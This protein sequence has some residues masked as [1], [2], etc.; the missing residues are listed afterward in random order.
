MYQQQATPRE[1]RSRIQDKTLK[2]LSVLLRSTRTSSSSG[3]PV[4]EQI[5]FV[6]STVAQALVL[7]D[8]DKWLSAISLEN[9]SMSTFG[10]FEVVLKSSVPEGKRVLPS[11]YHL[12]KKKDG[13]YKARLV[14]G[15]HRQ[16]AYTD[17]NP[18]GTYSA[19]LNDKTMLILLDIAA[20]CRLK[21]R[22]ADISTAFLHAPLDEGEEIYMKAPQGMDGVSPDCVLRLKKCLY[23]LKQAPKKWFETLTSHLVAFGLK[24]SSFDPCIFS[25]TD[26]EGHT[27]FVAC[28]VD[29]LFM[30]S[31]SE[32]TTDAFISFLSSRLTVK[33]LGEPTE[34]VHYQ[35]ATKHDGIYIHQRRHLENILIE[36]DM[37]NCSPTLTPT[38]D[39]TPVADDAPAC[40]DP[41]LY[42]SIVGKILYV[43]THSRPDLCYSASELAR[44]SSAPKEA[45][46]KRV[47][48][49]VRY[50][51]GT[52]DRAIFFPYRDCTVANYTA[53][54]SCFTDATWASDV[55]DRSSRSGGVILLN[56]TPVA[57]FTKRQKSIALSSCESELVALSLGIVESIWINNLLR[58]I[59]TKPSTTLYCDNQ[60]T[61]SAA[62]NASSMSSR[63]KHVQ[64]RQNF[65][66][67]SIDNNR[68]QTSWVPSESN[69]ADICTKGSTKTFLSNNLSRL[70]VEFDK[71]Q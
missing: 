28:F 4:T 5:E 67:Q 55:Q 50:I 13:T 27:L 51:A 36:S 33:D 26:L 40:D 48:T 12:T 63:L 16:V 24:P 23:G 31:S 62:A 69:L 17:Y 30:A 61:L 44:Y 8:R 1:R 15:G 25:Y 14:I 56:A 11:R 49:V 52:L 10:T 7:P 60:S 47:K 22:Q 65:V 21:L 64:I 54:L 19:T 20:S 39:T 68:Y 2:A 34:Y 32:R 37:A 66:H 71:R 41:E 46:W 9:T 70:L 35:I 59:I 45:H 6:P 57:W 38:F 3:S 58:S 18:L 53:K 42:R 29:D 43:A